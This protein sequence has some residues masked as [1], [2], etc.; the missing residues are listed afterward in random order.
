MHDD[1]KFTQPRDLLVPTPPKM[2]DDHHHPAD[3]LA[4]ATNENN[5]NL[6]QNHINV[7]YIQNCTI[8]QRA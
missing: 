3:P 1:L 6:L 5:L 4:P 8:I 2:N 7:L